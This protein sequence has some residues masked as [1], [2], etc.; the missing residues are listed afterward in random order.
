MLRF[1][2]NKDKSSEGG[3][4]N[5]SPFDAEVRSPSCISPKS[6]TNYS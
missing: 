5:V 1:G 3:N 2:K 4:F 6:F